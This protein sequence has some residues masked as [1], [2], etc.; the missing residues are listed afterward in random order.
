MSIDVIRYEP[1]TSFLR[2]FKFFFQQLKKVLRL[3]QVASLSDLRMI[4]I[5][6]KIC[7][8]EFTSCKRLQNGLHFVISYM[9]QN[10]TLQN[11]SFFVNYR[12]DIVD[13]T[14]CH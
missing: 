14:Y 7:Y 6:N 13:V 10:R 4:G 8:F 9:K 2:P 3:F 1:H 5:H 12:E 11:Q